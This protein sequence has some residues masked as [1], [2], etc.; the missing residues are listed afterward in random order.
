M[1]AETSRPIARPSL[2][3]TQDDP[4]ER[5]F[6]RRLRLYQELTVRG[7]VALFIVAFQLVF[8]VDP[9]VVARCI[10][11]LALLGLFLN[12]PYFLAARNGRAFRAQAHVRM[13]VDVLLI[14]VGLYFAGGLAAAHFLGIYL[15]VMIFAGMTLSSRAC[16]TATAAATGSYITIV[17]LQ[18]AGVLSAPFELPNATMIAAF[19]LILLNIAGALTAVLSRA[20]RESRRRLRATYQDLERFVEAIPD[21][22]YVVDRAGRLTLWNQKLESVT[23]RG[24]EALRGELLTELLAEDDRET[25]GAALRAALEDRP[26]E[27]ESRL[28]G[29]DGALIAYQWTGAALTDEHGRVS[30]LTGVGRDVT[31]R[32][33]AEDILRQRETEMRQLQKIEAIG[34]LAGGVAHDF[35]NVLT[36]VI[37]RCQLMLSRYQPDD[38]AYQDLDQIEST[39]QRAATLT[40]QLLAFSRNQ[41]S[42]RQP[43]DLNATV[44]SVSDMLARLIGENIELAVTLDPKLDLVMGDP[45]Q[46]EQVIVNFAVNAR[47]A[48][49]NGG[50]LTISTRNVM[51]NA[52]FVAAH[53]TV[54][55]GPHVLLEVQDTGVGMDEA[56]LQRAFEPFFTT[57]EAGKGCGLGLSTVY[58]I[59]KQHEGYAAVESTPGSGATFR[60]YLPRIEAPVAAPRDESGRGPLPRGEETI[61][62]VEDEAAVRGLVREILSRL[63]YRVLVASDGI[64]ALAVSQRF[65]E[66]IHLLLTDVIMPGMD[67]RELAERMMVARPD[68]RTLFMSGYADPPIP[69]DVLL[70]KPVTPDALARKVAEVLRQ[71]AL[72][73]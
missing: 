71:P 3:R 56:T 50:R 26:F 67:G 35:N 43:L 45:G 18:H 5:Q 17:S 72:A 34:R 28:R 64:E 19:N 23:G 40:R 47:D 61:L 11:L 21:V 14:S 57:K 65:A 38:P 73:G 48:M 69:D 36:V 54:A 68:T 37:G 13:L 20:L 42:A 60:V 51:L 30:G 6:G 24:H 52:A 44:T 66:P 58:G 29:A 7:G 55:A 46:I 62:L 9:P 22:I 12:G 49:P 8:P 25:F 31:E 63:G 59:V 39:A 27:I 33:R 10:T 4:A 32:K 2:E 53:P 1:V 16:L 41:A 70:E 15:I